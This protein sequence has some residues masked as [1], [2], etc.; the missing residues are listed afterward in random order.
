MKAARFQWNNNGISVPLLP[1]AFCM[2]RLEF[3]IEQDEESDVFVASWD[4]PAGGGIT[5]QAKSLAELHSAIQESVR[6]HFADR[7][8]VTSGL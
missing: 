3:K 1:I 6:C 4:D 5:T 7:P 8:S 2:E